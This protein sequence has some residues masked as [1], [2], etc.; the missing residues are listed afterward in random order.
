MTTSSQPQTDY[1][2]TPDL[3][4]ISILTGLADHFGREWCKPNQDKICELMKRFHG[5]I[6]SRRN[7]NRHLGALERDGWIERIRRHRRARDGSL[8]LH[9]TCY[10]LK[11]RARNALAALHNGWRN[12]CAPAARR[13][14]SPAVP[15]PAQSVVPPYPIV[16][17]QQ[18]PA[19]PAG[20]IDR[21]RALL[22]AGRR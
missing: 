15:N 21:M 17:L 16:E 10:R 3:R 11:R 13:P 6:M 19:T 5:R 22:R 8:E 2:V 12:F 9:S 18:Y 20:Y 14:R 1:V 7:L 4:V